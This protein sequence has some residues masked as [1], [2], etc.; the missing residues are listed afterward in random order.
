[1]E[2]GVR[3]QFSPVSVSAPPNELCASSDRI[4]LRAERF[5]PV[6]LIIVLINVFDAGV[7]RILSSRFRR[8]FRVAT[9]LAH[10]KATTSSASVPYRA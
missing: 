5:G 2:F 9:P 6:D 1:M 4:N 7:E 10:R 3:T 8:S